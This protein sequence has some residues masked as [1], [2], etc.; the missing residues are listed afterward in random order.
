[1]DE[2]IKIDFTHNGMGL[3]PISQSFYYLKSLIHTLYYI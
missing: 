3:I 2:V 1:M